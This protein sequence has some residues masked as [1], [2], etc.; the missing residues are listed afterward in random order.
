MTKKVYL[1]K[2]A[3]IKKILWRVKESL[4]DRSFYF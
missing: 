3:T 2:Q 1:I 4:P